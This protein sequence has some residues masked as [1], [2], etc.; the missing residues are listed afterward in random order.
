MNP[1]S[2]PD[3]KHLA[4]RRSRPKSANAPDSDT[5]KSGEEYRV[6][7]G[8]PPKEYRFKPGQSGNP[9]GAK[10]KTPSI[11]PDLKALL[12]RALNAKVK[13]R[14]GERDKIVTKAAAGIEQLVDQFAKGDPRARRDLILLCETLGVD[15]TNRKALEGALE[16]VLSAE[17]EALLADFVKRHGGQ[18]PFGAEQAKDAN[19]LTSPS[20]NGKL[21]APPFENLI[22][23][24]IR[25]A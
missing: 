10:R 3:R 19:L 18:Y 8:R 25:Q 14:R 4:N 21:L 9:E 7:P 17:D 13:L 11:A 6:G 20:E 12:E 22:D 1:S 5:Q 15:L 16:D 24:Q 23:S 2:K